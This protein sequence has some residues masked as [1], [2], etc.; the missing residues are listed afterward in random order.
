MKLDSAE[1]TN[2]ALSSL[3]DKYFKASTFLEA[4]DVWARVEDE[5]G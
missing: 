2:A 5:C 1:H 4:S 3:Q